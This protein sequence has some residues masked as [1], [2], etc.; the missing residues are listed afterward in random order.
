MAF[1]TARMR[2]IKRCSLGLL[3]LA[4]EIAVAGCSSHQGS[5]PRIS[6]LSNSQADTLNA[7]HSRF[8]KSED[9]PVEPSTHFAAGQLAEAQGL[10]A[11]AIQQYQA[12]IASDPQHAPSLYR[13][14]LLY[15]Q[16]RD[17]KCA[18]D[19]WTRYVEVTGGEA[20]AY[21]NLGFCYELA[22]RTADAEN[23]Y[24][25]GIA[26]DPKDGPCRVNYGL[27]LARAGRT[28]EATAQFQAVLPPAQVQYNLASVYEQQGKRD[29][30]RQAYETALQLDPNLTEARTRLASL[31]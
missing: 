3:A 25:L 23:A 31:E 26:R 6:G 20:T 13:L 4:L 27:L 2:R 10:T 19:T 15:C 11:T 14:G 16:Q 9:P 22:E 29:Q 18:I 24:K 1:K 12:A 17:F 21:A 28:D 7:Q 8:E 5:G 30:A